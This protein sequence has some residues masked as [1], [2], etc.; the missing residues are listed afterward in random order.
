M[1]WAQD[2]YDF[3]ECEKATVELVKDSE[4]E[5]A[6]VAISGHLRQIPDSDPS[7]LRSLEVPGPDR[8]PGN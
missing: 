6:Q 3:L 4:F 5:A 2:F 7:N 8:I 1:R